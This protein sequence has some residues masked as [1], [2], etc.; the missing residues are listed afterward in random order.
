MSSKKGIPL[1]HQSTEYYP[2]GPGGH[3]DVFWQI[4]D[5]AVLFGQQW[6]MPWMPF[7][8]QCLLRFYMPCHELFLKNV[9]QKCI[10][11]DALNSSD[12]WFL[13]QPL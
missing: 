7:F 11:L 3:L 10:L 5:K 8:V 12:V 4:Q 2:W 1:T 13:S 6:L 9:S